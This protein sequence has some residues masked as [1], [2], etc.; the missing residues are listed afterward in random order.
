MVVMAKVHDAE[1]KEAVLEL[2]HFATVIAIVMRK[3]HHSP[4][5]QDLYDAA[6]KLAANVERRLTDTTT[7]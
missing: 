3:V 7:H 4:E 5:C 2:A 6:I 1:L